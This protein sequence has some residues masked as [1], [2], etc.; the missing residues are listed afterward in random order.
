MALTVM[1]HV[2]HLLGIGH[3]RR[4]AAITRELCRQ[5][6]RVCYVTGGVAVNGLDIA[7]A[8]MVQLP[9]AKVADARFE[10]LM[11]ETGRR[12][13]EEWRGQRKR[14]L[15][16]TFHL[17]RPDVLLIETFPFGRK[18]LSFE[19]QPLLEA[20]W[21]SHPRPLV[22]SSIRDILQPKPSARNQQIVDLIRRYF[23]VVLV[24]GDRQ[25]VALS[26]SFSAAGAIES[27][28]EYT[29]YV[30]EPAPTSTTRRRRGRDV[31]ISTGGGYGGE[32]LLRVALR[33][34]RLL[35][36]DAP[37][38]R[39]MVGDNLP[40]GLLQE[41]RDL[42]PRGVTLERNRSDFPGLLAGAAVSVSQAGYN[43]VIEILAAGTPAVLVPFEEEDE[44]EQSIRARVLGERG[45]AQVLKPKELSPQVLL[46]AI[47][48]AR[49]LVPVETKPPD[50]NGAA[51]SANIIREW[52]ARSR[53]VD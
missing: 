30:V 5:G 31:L 51:S 46:A 8:E 35:G 10:Y 40:E 45:M 39:C 29:G 22:V 19:L 6:M 38:W 17:T 2:Q 18:M 25:F 3:Q 12:V 4:A 47:E 32:Q 33:S 43:T 44:I 20:A 27:R 53:K 50:T 1:W 42:A 16:D 34:R 13:D 26:D 52:L 15:L 23:D 11:D 7:T 14:Q 48:S 24:H 37:G 9:P 28:V 21:E 41:L 36:A 49:E